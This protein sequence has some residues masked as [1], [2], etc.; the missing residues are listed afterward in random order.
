MEEAG[1]NQRYHL[2]WMASSRRW[3]KKYKAVVYYFPAK[4]NE[5]KEISY[6]RCWQEWLEKKTEIDGEAYSK[7][8]ILW[9]HL[10]D[11]VSEGREKAEEE[12][13]RSG[14]TLSNNWLNTIRYAIEHQLPFPVTPS[15]EETKLGNVMDG[16]ALLGDQADPRQTIG[17]PPWELATRTPKESVGANATEFLEMVEKR[18]QNGEVSAAW[19]DSLQRG[20]VE[21]KNWIGEHTPVTSINGKILESY[22][23]NISEHVSTGRW[24][25]HTGKD[26]WSVGKQFIKWLWEVEALESLPRN[27]SRL[28]WEVAPK[29]IETFGTAQLTLLLGEATG[30]LRLHLLLMANC[31]FGQTDIAELQPD[32]VNWSEGRIIRKRSKTA[33]WEG[34]PVVNY[35][36]W[37]ETLKLLKQYKTTDAEHV[38]LTSQGKPLRSTRLEGGKVKKA[39]SIK[40]A[41]RRLRDKLDNDPG[42]PMKLIRKTC[43]SLLAEEYDESLAAH[44]LGHAPRSIAGKHYI[45]PS[46][47]KFDEAIK[48]LGKQFGY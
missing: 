14:W 18:S 46:Q 1:Y 15:P 3:R 8:R 48:W 31:G 26:F 4:P 47:D 38:L 13:S 36:L 2:T 28:R 11:Y 9:E 43:A 23:A 30:P 44:F 24:S 22:R 7:D 21:F 41:F 17:P 19:Y 32:E 40:L 35:T 6:R 16:T 20:V 33:Q 45:K 10:L 39:D 34:V 25:N 29:A 5:T 37:D 42:K 12:N 27:F